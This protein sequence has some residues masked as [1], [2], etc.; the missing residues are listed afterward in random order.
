MKIEK[1]A[2]KN[3]FSIAASQIDICDDAH[4]DEDTSAKFNDVDAAAVIFSMG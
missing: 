4:I 1:R 3:G 2:D